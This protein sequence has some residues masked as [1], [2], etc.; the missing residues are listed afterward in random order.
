MLFEFLKDNRKLLAEKWF[1]SAVETYPSDSS[2]FLVKQKDQF[3][4]PIGTTLRTVTERLIDEL[5]GEMNSEV[6]LEAVDDL[7]RIRAVQEFSP[8][9]ALALLFDIKRIVREQTSDMLSDS[10]R[11]LA[12]FESRVDLVVLHAFDRYEAKREKMFEIRAREAQMRVQKLMDR[13][14]ATGS[15][16]ADPVLLDPDPRGDPKGHDED[17]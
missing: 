8:S 17:S 4:N 13:M 12:E 15:S 3:A 11:E 7:A 10:S 5:S 16:V 14:M 2:G 1:N 9:Q 6:I